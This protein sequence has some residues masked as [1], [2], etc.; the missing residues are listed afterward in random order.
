MNRTQQLRG[1]RVSRT[2]Q[3]RLFFKVFKR[4][5]GKTPAAYARGLGDSAE[6]GKTT[7]MRITIIAT[8]VDDRA[9]VMVK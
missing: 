4:E 2:P 5:T 7:D 8:R 9:S 6:G 1:H 3:W